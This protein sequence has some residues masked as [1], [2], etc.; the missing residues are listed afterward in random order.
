MD[1]SALT[2]LYE[3]TRALGLSDDLE[4]G[5]L[6]YERAQSLAKHR[7]VV[8]EG[9]PYDVMCLLAHAVVSSAR[10]GERRHCHTSADRWWTSV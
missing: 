3:S 6:L 1:L 4:V 9:Q 5:F 2:A 7:V 10:E 8:Y